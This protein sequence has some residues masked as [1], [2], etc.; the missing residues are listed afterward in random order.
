MTT[1]ASPGAETA[2]VGYS[3]LNTKN[4]G[5]QEVLHGFKT[6]VRQTNCA[7]YLFLIAELD[8]WK[9]TVHTLA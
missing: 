8:V 4:N 9:D 1:K 7:R 3:V 2:A 5:V 6:Q